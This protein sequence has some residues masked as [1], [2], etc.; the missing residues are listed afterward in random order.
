MG[1]PTPQGVPMPECIGHEERTWRTETSKYPQEKKATAIPSVAAS[2]RGWVDGRLKRMET[3]ATEGESPVSESQ[4]KPS[5]RP[6]LVEPGLNMG[7]PPSKA[8]YSST[9]DSESVRRLNDDKHRD[10]RSER[11]PE[12]MCLQAVGAPSGVTA[13]FL[14]NEPAS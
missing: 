1:Q 6:G 14:H 10:E 7:G 11:V 8:K 3:R 9:T 4:P 5:S 13:C 2:E 12:T